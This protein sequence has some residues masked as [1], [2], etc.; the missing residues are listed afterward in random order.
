MWEILVKALC[1][2]LIFEGMF[3]FISPHGWRRA[4]AT[5]AQLKDEQ[6]R[7]MGLVAMAIGSLLL[8]LV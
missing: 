8:W 2:V 5:I 1:L 4:I 3:P 7:I 6:L